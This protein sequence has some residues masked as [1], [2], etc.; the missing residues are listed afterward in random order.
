MIQDTIP[1]NALVGLPDF[2][3]PT[4]GAI[5]IVPPHEAMV[6]AFDR[7]FHFG[8]S[9]YEVCRTYDGVPLALPEHLRRLRQSARMAMFADFPE[10]SIIESMI[11][12]TCH[13][14][15]T[16]F[17]SHDVY[18]R[19]VVSRGLSDLN[20][21]PHLASPSYPL[22]FVKKLEPVSQS[23][24]D[25]GVHF[26]VT[27]RRRNHP[28][29]LDPAMKSGNYLNNVLAMGE[30][31][32]HGAHD[33]LMLSQQGFV[34]EGTTNNFFAVIDGSVWTAPLSV[35]IL[36]GITRELVFES[37]RNLGIDYQE[38]LFTVDDLKRASEMFLS[39][40]IKE[41]LAITKLNELSVGDGKP[42]PVS[43][44]LRTELR[45]LIQKRTAANAGQRLV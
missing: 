16:K 6:P 37:C 38:R 26:W 27:E 11:Q 41:V 3:N 42:G 35:G 36:A 33:A 9:V 7:S 43:K 39:S 28:S 32:A 15:R 22:V 20:I 24:A 40:S 13:T 25:Q 45:A 31:L 1:K 18:I 30:A 21:N 10:M 2:R 4:S 34:T 5:Q 19:V 17:G 44:K 8:D 12:R 23:V 14:Y 29:A